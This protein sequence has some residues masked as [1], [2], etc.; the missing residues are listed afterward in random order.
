MKK[1]DPGEGSGIPPPSTPPTTAAS[2][3][4]AVAALF[5]FGRS[6]YVLETT[7]ELALPA[8]PANRGGAAGEEEYR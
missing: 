8:R 4:P 5:S 6:G 1:P 3:R 2:P 7:Q